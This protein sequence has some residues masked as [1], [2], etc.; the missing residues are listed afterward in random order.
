MSDVGV[1]LRVPGVDRTFIRDYFARK[2]LLDV[3][4]E[5]EKRA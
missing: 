2:G 3:F 4:D 5:I 1:L